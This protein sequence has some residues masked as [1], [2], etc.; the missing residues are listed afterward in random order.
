[1]R[2]PIPALVLVFLFSIPAAAGPKRLLKDWTFYA[3]EAIMAAAESAD[4]YSTC[5]G[6][7]FGYPEQHW[8]A[9]G[10]LSCRNT[11]LRLAGG[12]A[13]YTG[14]NVLEFKLFR[15][16]RNRVIRELTPGMVP[17][18]VA[19]LHSYF[20]ARNLTLSAPRR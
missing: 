5:R 13:F 8:P 9:A 17:G 15:H 12:F 3:G 6:M 2:R 16:D 11:G 14:L 18:A 7:A 20:A 10:S 4:G 19:G 1:M